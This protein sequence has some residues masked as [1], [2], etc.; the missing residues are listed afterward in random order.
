M[1][2][3]LFLLWIFGA[4]VAWGEP[5]PLS[6][7]VGNFVVADVE[8]GGQHARLLFDTGAGVTSITPAFAQRIGCAQRGSLTG[9]RVSGE[10]IALQKCE[11]VHVSIGRR[12]IVRDLGVFDLATLLPADLPALDGVIGLDAFDGAEITLRLSDRT[13][14]VGHR[15][16]RGWREGEIRVQREMGGLGV[17]VFTR[18]QAH[19]GSL[20]MLLDSGNVGPALL[21]PGAL[22]QLNTTT[23]PASLTV[24]GVGLHEVQSSQLASSIYDGNLGWAFLRDFEIALDLRHNRI[25]WRPAPR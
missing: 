20:W 14:D 22:S 5:L 13:I 2:I 15:Q 11:Q 8:I 9:F 12:Q 4:S 17:S 10:R 7:Y 23:P 21:S 6:R 18:A 19:E 16:G 25:W 1:R 24:A 3:L